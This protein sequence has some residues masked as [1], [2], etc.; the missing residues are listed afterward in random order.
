MKTKE[1]KLNVSYLNK[2]GVEVK[3]VKRIKTKAT[4]QCPAFTSFLLDNGQ[5]VS[6]NKLKPI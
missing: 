6:A 1:I 2:E 3:V 4:R 5:T